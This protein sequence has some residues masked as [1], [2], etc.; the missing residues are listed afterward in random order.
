MLQELAAHS[1]TTD[2]TIVSKRM[3]GDSGK[4]SIW[5]DEI[6]RNECYQIDGAKQRGPDWEGPKFWL[7]N[8]RGKWRFQSV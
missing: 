3:E 6:S 1:L 8:I 5:G 7:A 4:W 2:A